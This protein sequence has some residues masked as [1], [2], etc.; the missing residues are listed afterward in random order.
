MKQVFNSSKSKIDNSPNKNDI[1]K[2]ID[3][4]VN[5]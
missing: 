2:K 4:N 1:K 5:G 3:G